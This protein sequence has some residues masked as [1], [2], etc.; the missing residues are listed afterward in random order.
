[1][2][3]MVSQITGNWTVV[4]TAYLGWVQIK[5]NISLSN[6]NSP[7]TGEFPA[8]R[9]SNTANVSIWWR[10]DVDSKRIPSL[11][12]ALTANDMESISM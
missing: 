4:S 12:K 11:T 10:H 6:G 1:M 7:V 9:A 5:E 2:K 3:I 8:Q